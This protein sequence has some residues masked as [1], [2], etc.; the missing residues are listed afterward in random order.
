MAAGEDPGVLAGVPV[1]AVDGYIAKPIE[2]RP[3]LREGHPLIERAIPLSLGDNYK[4]YR[5]VGTT[6]QLADLYQA[7]IG[8]GR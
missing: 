6:H 8:A 3:F 1:K 4:G 5:V 2:A 7:G